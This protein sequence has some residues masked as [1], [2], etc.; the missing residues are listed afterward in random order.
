MVNKY[1]CK[2]ASKIHLSEGL[3]LI[4]FLIVVAI[5]SVV[6]LALLSLFASGYKHFINQDALADAVDDSQYP[7][8]WLAKDIMEEN[9]ALSMNNLLKELEKLEE[10]MKHIEDVVNKEEPAED[11][12]SAI[13]ELISKH[14]STN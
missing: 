5:S 8:R 10:A 13:K 11:R 12:I 7:V 6:M 14:K 4:E 2:R 1:K 3:S 9:A